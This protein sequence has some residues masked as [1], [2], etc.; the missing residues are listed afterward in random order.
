M[1]F[2]TLLWCQRKAYQQH[3]EFLNNT[4]PFPAK[5]RNQWELGLKVGAFALSS[6]VRSRFPGF[7]AGYTCVKHWD[8][9]SR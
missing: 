1:M 6:D 8:M 9:Y 5:P 7:G 3:N 2:L 4:Y